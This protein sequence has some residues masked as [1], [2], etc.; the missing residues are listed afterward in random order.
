MSSP[1]DCLTGLKETRGPA[2]ASFV[3][4]ISSSKLTIPD[5]RS[6]FWTILMYSHESYE[7]LQDL[8]SRMNLFDHH[9]IIS[10]KSSNTACK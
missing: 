3:D 8:Y 1:L 10:Y 2:I 7:Q 5:I 9:L 6:G 4:V